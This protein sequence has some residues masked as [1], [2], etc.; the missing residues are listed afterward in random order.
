MK[1]PK[2]R[3]KLIFETTI[4]ATLLINALGYMGAYLL[5]HH[6]NTDEFGIG[7]P[8]SQIYSLPTELGLQYSNQKIEINNHEWLSTWLIKAKN[9]QG[10]VIL[11]TGIQPP[12][13]IYDKGLIRFR[14]SV[15]ISVKLT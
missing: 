3:T 8:R 7:L 6:R 4:T 5:T 2:L 11:L 9:P 12:K 15:K 1:L 13:S 10:T 14:N